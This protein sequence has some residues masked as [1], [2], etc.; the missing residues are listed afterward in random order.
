MGRSSG[1]QWGD[2]AAAYGEI[3]MAAVTPRAQAPRRQPLGVTVQLCALRWLGF[4]P[5]DLAAISQHVT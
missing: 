1:R 5:D 4:V 2:S 3:S